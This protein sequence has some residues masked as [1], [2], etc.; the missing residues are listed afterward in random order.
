[1]ERLRSIS[2]IKKAEQKAKSFLAT[3]LLGI[4]LL[5]GCDINGG[6][7]NGIEVQRESICGKSVTISTPDNAKAIWVFGRRFEIDKKGFIKDF[8]VNPKTGEILYKGDINGDRV[9]DEIRANPK[10]EITEFILNC[11]STE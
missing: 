2:E 5:T 8:W 7:V 1:M 10:G 3:A 9:P 11:G 6:V 4:L